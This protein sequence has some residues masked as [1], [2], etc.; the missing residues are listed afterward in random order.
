MR[1]KRARKRLASGTFSDMRAFRRA[2]IVASVVPLDSDIPIADGA[3]I[4]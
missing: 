2:R 1:E 3:I 4:T